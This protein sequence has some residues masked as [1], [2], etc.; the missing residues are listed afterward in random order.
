MDLHAYLPTFLSILLLN[1][2][3]SLFFFYL[4]SQEDVETFLIKFNETVGASYAVE[5][6]LGVFNELYSKYKYME[7]SFEKSKNVYKAKVPEIEQTIELIKLMIKKHEDEEEM[8]T[9]YN[10]CDTLYAV[11]KVFRYDRYL[12]ALL[13]P[14]NGAA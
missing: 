1:H 2:H 14:S 5:A 13:V 10:L 6:A 9:N 11:A 12:L 7:A 4:V 8:I 3:Y